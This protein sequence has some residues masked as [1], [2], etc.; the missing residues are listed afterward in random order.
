[1]NLK[2]VVSWQCF[3]EVSW[4][5]ANILI[6]LDAHLEHLIDKC[7]YN[8]LPATKFLAIDCKN[9]YLCSCWVNHWAHSLQQKFVIHPKRYTSCTRHPNNNSNTTHIGVGSTVTCICGIIFWRMKSKTNIEQFACLFYVW[10]NPPLWRSWYADW[11]CALA[12]EHM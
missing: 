12:S 6:W 4:M 3:A 7:R 5:P 11:Y 2:Q 1:M 8:T 9:E 10:G